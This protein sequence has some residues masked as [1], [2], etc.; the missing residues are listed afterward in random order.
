MWNLNVL[1]VV[2]A[3]GGIGSNHVFADVYLQDNFDSQTIPL[4]NP[5]I[6]HDY[7]LTDSNG[8]PFSLSTNPALGSQSLKLIREGADNP[9]IDMRTNDGL[10]KDGATVEFDWAV[11]QEH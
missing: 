10:M 4:H 6:G 5:P 2:V 7:R 8:N 9:T 1:A 11:N 3:V